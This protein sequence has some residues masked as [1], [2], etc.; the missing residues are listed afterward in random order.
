MP[1]VKRLTQK[2]ENYEIKT[3]S[4]KKSEKGANAKL[5]DFPVFSPWIH[6]VKETNLKKDASLWFND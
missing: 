3:E 1:F 6:F 2:Q 4:L 5:S